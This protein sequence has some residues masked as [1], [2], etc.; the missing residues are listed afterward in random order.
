VHF[1][2]PPVGQRGDVLD[3]DACIARGDGVGDRTVTTT[4]IC[5]AT[6]R[7]ASR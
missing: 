2:E 3:H 1:A 5:R 7:R 4:R 6:W